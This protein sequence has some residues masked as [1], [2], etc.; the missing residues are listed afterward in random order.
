MWP[1]ALTSKCR[2]M[3]WN[4]ST[5]RAGA[6]G[7][8]HPQ[9]QPAQAAADLR[10][11]GEAGQAVVAQVQRGQLAAGAQVGEHADVVA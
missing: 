7:A 5:R 6:Q 8:A 9:N 1:T 2:A 4:R 11:A 3:T 10:G